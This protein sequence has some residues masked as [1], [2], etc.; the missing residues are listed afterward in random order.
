MGAYLEGSQGRPRAGA[1]PQLKCQCRPRGVPGQGT[2]S[3]PS[4]DG[5]DPSCPR[6]PTIWLAW[7]GAEGRPGSQRGPSPLA[8]GLRRPARAPLLTLGPDSSQTCQGWA[9][10]YRQVSRSQVG[11]QAD[12]SSSTF[13]CCSDTC[14]LAAWQPPPSTAHPILGPIEDG[15]PQY[16]T[17]LSLF[18]WHVGTCGHPPLLLPG[19]CSICPP[20]HTPFNLLPIQEA[21]G[22]S[23][24][25]GR[26]L[27]HCPR[28]WRPLPTVSPLR[29][30][31]QP[32]HKQTAPTPRPPHVIPLAPG[33]SQTGLPR[34]HSHLAPLKLRM[35]VVAQQGALAGQQP[36]AQG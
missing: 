12:G 23:C 20:T 1:H 7:L 15:R 17:R 21:P 25:P 13:H 3:Q 10:P 26:Q 32:C 27:P 36:G 29:A 34:S 2:R 6:P 33:S 31:L 18:P 30:L 16:T 8:G 9:P 4:E 24:T 11:R 28:A 14:H 22:P 19:Q 35:L 5:S